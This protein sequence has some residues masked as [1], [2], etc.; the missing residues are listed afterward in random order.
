MDP[1]PKKPAVTCLGCDFPFASRSALFR[2]LRATG[3]GGTE[4]RRTDRFVVHFGY[5]GT[6][7]FGSQRNAKADEARCPTVEGA[8]LAAVERAALRQSGATGC[9]AEVRSRT[10]RTDRGVHALANVIHLLTRTTFAPGTASPPPISEPAWLA[11]VRA[12]LPQ[13]ELTVLRRF[14]VPSHDTNVRKLCQKREYRPV[15]RFKVAVM[16]NTA[17]LLHARI[18][19]CCGPAPQ[20]SGTI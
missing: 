19:F 7:W 16:A 18:A 20:A 15:V 11:A 13:S 12:E 6:T 1:T 8:L 17:G 9:T 2:H 10:S 5:V 3:C 4:V 14:D